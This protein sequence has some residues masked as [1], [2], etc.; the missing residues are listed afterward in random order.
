MTRFT[1]NDAT[2]SERQSDTKQLTTALWITV[3]IILWSIVAAVFFRELCWV[4]IL[5]ALLLTAVIGVSAILVGFKSKR[6]TDAGYFVFFLIGLVLIIIGITFYIFYQLFG[7]SFA[8]EVLILLSVLI[9]PCNSVLRFIYCVAA[10]FLM[11]S[12]RI[13][14]TG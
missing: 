9:T 12:D 11:E 14:L 4:Y 6:L 7:V 10:G 8:L 3:I 5:I 13:I 2:G 1:F